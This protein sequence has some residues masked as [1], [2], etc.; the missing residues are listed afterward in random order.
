MIRWGIFWCFRLDLTS[1]RLTGRNPPT[2]VECV[3]DNTST[4]SWTIES[5]YTQ[6]LTQFWYGG[7]IRDGLTS[8][9]LKSKVAEQ[10]S[11]NTPEN[12]SSLNVVYF[13]QL[14][15][16][17]QLRPVGSIWH[18][19]RIFNLHTLARGVAKQ[20]QHWSSRRLGLS[21]ELQSSVLDIVL[22]C[23]LYCCG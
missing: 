2:Q 17:C 16:Q 18:V 14:G 5:T 11:L 7:N 13:P 6:G 19:H 12:I 4:K 9:H 15:Y 1:L 10:I 20:R 21:G 8:P 22:Y 23:V 3:S